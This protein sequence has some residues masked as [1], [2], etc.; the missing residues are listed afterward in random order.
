M[1]RSY[2]GPMGLL[3]LI[4]VC[5][6]LFLGF[7]FYIVKQWGLKDDNLLSTDKAAIAVVELKG[8]IW[9]S[10]KLIELLM[11]AEENENIKAVIVSIDSPG[12]AVAPSQE[13]YEEVRRIDQI[14]PVYAVLGSIA[15]SGGYYVASATRK[16]YASGG[17]LTGSIGAIIQTMDL[18]RLFEWAKVNPEVI[19]AGKYKDLGGPHRPLTEEERQ[20]MEETIKD[21]HLQFKEDILR[22]RKEKIKGPI[23]QYAQGQV[24]TGLQAKKYG[25]VDEVKGLWSAGREI[26]KELKLPGKFKLQFLKPKKKN[27]SL[28]EFMQY[29]DETKSMLTQWS[30]YSKLPLLRLNQ[31]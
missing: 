12:G 3:L 31:F 17:T 1:D 24:F 16:I 27:L 20:M 11:E 22:T 15:A 10:Q 26:H 14:K 29:V 2:Q 4:F 21:I 23:E 30:T 19:K 7:C 9:E 13:I 25:L 5:F 18:S 8:E 28:G 6:L